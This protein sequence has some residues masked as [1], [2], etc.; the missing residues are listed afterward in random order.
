MTADAS[1]TDIPQLLEHL[2]QSRFYGSLEI[3]L[4]AGRIVLLKKTETIKPTEE[5]AV[6]KALLKQSEANHGHTER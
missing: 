5:R 1:L 3:K 4:E 2:R 6:I